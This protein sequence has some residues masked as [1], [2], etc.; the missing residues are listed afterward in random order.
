MKTIDV[1]INSFQRTAVD[2]RKDIQTSL[3]AATLA[4]VHI[5]ILR[6]QAAQRDVIIRL[7]FPDT[8]TNN[9][10][11]GAVDAIKN[12]P[13]VVTLAPSQFQYI[14]GF[15]APTYAV[16]NLAGQDSWLLINSNNLD[17]GAAPD[18]SVSA[19]SPLVGSQSIILDSKG[20]GQVSSTRQPAD[21][22]AAMSGG[23]YAMGPGTSFKAKLL[24]T[25]T[26]PEP[27][28]LQEYVYNFGVRGGDA[29]LRYRATGGMLSLFGEFFAHTIVFDTAFDAEVTWLSDGKLQYKEGG[30]VK[31]TTAASYL[32]AS[33][34]PIVCSLSC[35]AILA[36]GNATMKVDSVDNL[37]VIE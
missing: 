33:A 21:V 11:Q 4:Q 36:G 19:T 25:K 12:T 9:D 27:T 32:G 16:G 13:G 8:L 26:G 1:F 37:L 2:I 31:A 5:K 29:S 15:E 28:G 23:S 6:D 17:A 7:V 20:N 14:T 10:F 34:A 18:M 24:L 35:G 30:V 22:A 3:G